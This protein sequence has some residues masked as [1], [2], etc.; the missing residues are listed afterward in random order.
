MGEGGAG[1]GSGASRAEVR[2]TVLHDALRQRKVCRS[3]GCLGEALWDQDG[4][5]RC[6]AQLWGDWESQL[7]LQADLFESRIRIGSHNWSTVY[8]YR[9]GYTGTDSRLLPEYVV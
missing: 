4:Q 1:G 9:Y 6:A 8:R 7:Q 3:S 2:P 5:H